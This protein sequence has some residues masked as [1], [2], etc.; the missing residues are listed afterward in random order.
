MSQIKTVLFDL[1]NVIAYIDFDAFW[2]SLGFIHPDEAAP[3]SQG[4][5]SWTARYETGLISTDDYLAGLCSVFNY[6]FTTIQLEDAFSGI[7][8]EPVEGM[9]DL[10]KLVAQTHSTALVSNTNDIHFRL[11]LNKY[12]ALSLIPK[13][14]TSFQLCVMKPAKEFYE[15]IIKDQGLAAS[16]LLFIDDIKENVEGAIYCGMC[17]LKF[18]DPAQLKIA[19]KD[20][21]VLV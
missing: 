7:M 9:L 21:R 14:Y 2:R 17:G 5:K 18:E 13:H 6:K 12:K 16:K 19:L 15:A 10:I 20:L 11:S 1:G 3:F 4:Y 8:L